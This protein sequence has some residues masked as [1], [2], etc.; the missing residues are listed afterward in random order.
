M[1]EL[2]MI[3]RLKAALR[4]AGLGPAQGWLRLV[5]GYELAQGKP[6]DSCKFMNSLRASV[7]DA[8]AWASD[9]TPTA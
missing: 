7:F 8:E 3:P 4:L 2:L 1:E 5:K 9:A 6:F